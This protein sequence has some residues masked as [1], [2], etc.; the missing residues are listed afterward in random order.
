M[1]EIAKVKDDMMKSIKQL[2][3]KRQ[4]QI[5]A[6]IFNREGNF[7]IED[8]AE[9]TQI[10]KRSVYYEMSV[11]KSVFKEF[12]VEI[13][14][15]GKSRFFLQASPEHIKNLKS[16]FSTKESGIMIPD[17]SE[18]VNYIIFQLLSRSEPVLI[19]E[20]ICR[21]GISK[22]TVIKD[23]QMAKVRL[24]KEHLC[25]LSRPNYGSYIS[26]E[27]VFIRN[28][29][30]NFIVNNYADTAFAL[31][32]ANK[33]IS[34]SG[35]C[36]EIEN[37]IISYF[38]K[39]LLWCCTRA[40]DNYSYSAEVEFS[41]QARVLVV[42]YFAITVKRVQA[43]HFVKINQSAVE[44]LQSTHY[45]S[46][47]LKVLDNFERYVGISIPDEERVYLL[48]QLLSGESKGKGE[49]LTK[50]IK[51]KLCEEV[52]K[53]VMKEAAAYLNPKL[54]ED[55][56]LYNNLLNHLYV[57]IMRSI[58]GIPIHNQLL[59]TIREQYSYA[60]F[61]AERCVEVIEKMI[62]SPVSKEETGY[63]AIYLE[64]A[65]EQIGKEFNELRAIILCVEGVATAWLLATSIANAFPDI[66]IIQVLS[67]REYYK[68][69]GLGGIDMIISTT[70]NVEQTGA[71][72][73]FLVVSPILTKNDLKVLNEF[74]QKK[75]FRKDEELPESERGKKNLLS[76]LQPE[77]I[78]VKECA[79]DWREVIEKASAP[80]VKA[81]R[82]T[83]E[84]VRAMKENIE[85][86][87]PYVVS[88]PGVA[89]LHANPKIRGTKL[90]L[91]LTT[92][93][94][95]VPFGE[96]GTNAVSIVFVLSSPDQEAHLKI[97]EDM[98]V[99]FQNEKVFADIN[100]AKEASEVIT[101]LKEVLTTPF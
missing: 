29:L 38:T 13:V 24:E 96:D 57:V 30:N 41:D 100:G 22:P 11:I 73:P 82:I 95:P 15:H 56:T 62:G 10:S 65:V 43:G 69:D 6:A 27:E 94:V 75:R 25:F 26:G 3:T 74:V 5:V 49:V 4:F 78:Q 46:C 64:A 97:L 21:F 44:E 9:D 63:L 14:K 98:V 61:V 55:E 39:H 60:Y 79:A 86:Y 80:M 67:V 87:G 16:Q 99:L 18:R 2:L 66:K 84:Y 72:I 88:F 51:G 90:G 70:R 20:F 83:K 68:Y 91:S 36:S 54:I 50:T 32:N 77:M 7:S 33:N 40:V 93:A 89:I 28:A 71:D 52:T 37:E 1:G 17:S 45:Y 48:I 76:I 42:F 53:T 19:K 31:I 23:F 12:K 85:N 101:I 92:L 35:K 47:M 58:N 8:I 81:A 59:P 34:L